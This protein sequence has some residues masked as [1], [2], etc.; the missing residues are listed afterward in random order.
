MI[1][2]MCI[3]LVYL[4]D[5]KRRTSTVRK[6]DELSLLQQSV[7]SE[8]NKTND[9]ISNTISDP[10]LAFCNYL[11]TQLRTLASDDFIKCQRKI[12]SLLFE[13]QDNYTQ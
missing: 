4:I 7:L 6:D 13:L 2:Y 11:A 9:S 1:Q 8:I 5:K 12:L 10:V 3:C